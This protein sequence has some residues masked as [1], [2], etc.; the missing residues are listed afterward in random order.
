M[1]VDP[2]HSLLVLLLFEAHQRQVCDL[3]A[4]VVAADVVLALFRAEATLLVP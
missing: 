4:E 2:G 1:C 3:F